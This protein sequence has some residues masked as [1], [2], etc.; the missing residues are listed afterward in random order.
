MSMYDITVN[1]ADNG[2]VIQEA[3]RTSEKDPVRYR[4]HVART[5]GELLRIIKSF[6]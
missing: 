6:A 4:T 2:W 1:K 5:V 3:Y